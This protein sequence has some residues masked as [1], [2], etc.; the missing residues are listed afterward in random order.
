MA[1]VDEAAGQRRILVTQLTIS[2][3]T[4]P[5]ELI[6]IE[7]QTKKRQNFRPTQSRSEIIQ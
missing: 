4:T 2:P 1:E 3:L 7:E 5:A 6:S